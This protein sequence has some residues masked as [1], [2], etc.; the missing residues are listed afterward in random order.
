M[1][2]GLLFWSVIAGVVTVAVSTA[3]LVAARNEKR[4][5]RALTLAEQVTL[6]DLE[7]AYH[8]PAYEG[9]RP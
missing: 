3:L 8:A 6:D 2:P 5:G 7:A 9:K 4:N 1:S